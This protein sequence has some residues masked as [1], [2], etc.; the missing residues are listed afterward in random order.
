MRRIS[1]VVIVSYERD[2]FRHSRIHGSCGLIL[3]AD[4]GWRLLENADSRP[5]LKGKDRIHPR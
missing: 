3:F 5:S 2:Q 4:R 1:L